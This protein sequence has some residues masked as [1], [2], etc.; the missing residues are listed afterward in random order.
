MGATSDPSLAAARAG[1]SPAAAQTAGGTAGRLEIGHPEL[2]ELHRHWEARRGERAMPSR[3][4]MDP[5]E[6]PRSLLAN[7]FLVD[8]EENPRRY[9]YRLVGTALTGVMKRELTGRYIDEMPLLFRKFALPAYAEVM[10]RGAPA[11]REVNAIEALWRIRYKR[12]LLPLSEDGARINMI[13][14]AI[15][16]I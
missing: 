6:L 13:L 14:G 8:V 16:R 1:A 5:V 4:D 12:L 9:R 3:A 10:E 15:F 7:L 2:R 11:Y